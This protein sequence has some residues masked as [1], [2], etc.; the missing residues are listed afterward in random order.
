MDASIPPTT[1][2]IT[3]EHS[4]QL[5][6]TLDLPGVEKMFQTLRTVPG[7]R[8]VEATAGSSR[9]YVQ[10]DDSLTS[11]QEIRNSVAR[12]GFPLL[13]APAHAGGG[14]CGSCGGH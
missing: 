8:A 1:Q 13:A 14:C 6:A 9:V 12:S 11:L 2:G 10:Y 3:M 7:V 4:L 5:S